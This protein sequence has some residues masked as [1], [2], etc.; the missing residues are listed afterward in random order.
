MLSGNAPATVFTSGTLSLI[1]PHAMAGCVVKGPDWKT[2]LYRGVTTFGDGLA[3]ITSILA[4]SVTES[5]PSAVASP[6]MKLTLSCVMRRCTAERPV[7]GLP[8]LS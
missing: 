3:T 2:N 1:Q 8:L 7:S 4:A 5:Q 6:R